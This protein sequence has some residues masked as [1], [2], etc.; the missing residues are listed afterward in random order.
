VDSIDHT[1]NAVWSPESEAKSVRHFLA[2]WSMST[3]V[4]NIN[5]DITNILASEMSM[6]IGNGKG[7]IDAAL[8]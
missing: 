4:K 2:S 3:A 6:N 1:D 7:S 8:A 5:I